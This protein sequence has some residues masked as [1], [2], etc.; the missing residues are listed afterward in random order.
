[1]DKLL[2]EIHE[3]EN[4]QVDTIAARRYLEDVIRLRRRELALRQKGFIK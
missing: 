4:I 3:L 1:M 2:R